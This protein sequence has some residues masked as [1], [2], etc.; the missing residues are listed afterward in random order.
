MSIKLNSTQI[1][2]A[3]KVLNNSKYNKTF[4]SNSTLKGDSEITRLVLSNK[5]DNHNFITYNLWLEEAPTLSYNFEF[6][7]FY[8]IV[9]KLDKDIDLNLESKNNNLIINAN[10]E[11]GSN[12]TL[13]LENQGQEENL[14]IRE[15]NSDIKFTLTLE[16]SEFIK[17]LEN[18]KK[19]L[20]SQEQG[21]NCI[22]NV[23]VSFEHD[24]LSLVTCDGFR[25]FNKLLDYKSPCDLTDSEEFFYINGKYIDVLIQSLKRLS[26][27]NK[28]RITDNILIC[29]YQNSIT[30]SYYEFIMYS[31]YLNSDKYIEYKKLYPNDSKTRLKVNKDSFIKDLEKIKI[32]GKGKLGMSIT[33]LGMDNENIRILSNS[34]NTKLKIEPKAVKSGND[35]KIAFNTDYML[36]MLKSV[37]DQEIEMLFNSDVDPILITSDSNKHMVLPIRLTEESKNF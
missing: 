29:V 6:K 8:N 22:K 3:L 2:N 9:S 33:Y 18:I 26:T 32:I 7:K 11:N 21:I 20:A 4:N 1:I 5:L 36:D 37:N 35:L 23:L 13:E 16:P 30:I 25:L 17:A 10:S 14:P 28:K 31:E 24:K 34:D 19:G 27:L 15:N 12:F